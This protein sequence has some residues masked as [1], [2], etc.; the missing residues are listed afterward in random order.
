MI[1]VTNSAVL[2]IKELM[3]QPENDGSHLRIGVNGG[4]CSG[5]EYFMGFDKEI[6][7]E[8]EVYNLD[9]FDLIVDSLSLPHLDGSEL[10]FTRDLMN[11]GFVFNNPNAT[12]TCGCGKSFCG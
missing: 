10:D 3:K 1:D 2:E 5:L 8:D 9:G 6:N 11:S 4:G 12:R 7:A